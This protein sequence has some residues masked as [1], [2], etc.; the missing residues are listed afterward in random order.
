MNIKTAKCLGPVADL[1]KHLPVDWWRSIFNSIYL[2]T[3]AD[4]VENDTATAHEIDIF[5][6]FSKIEPSDH[7]LDLCCGQGRHSLELAKRGY[8]FITGIDRSR[9][10]IRLARSRSQK[11]GYPIKFSEGDARKVKLADQSMDCVMMMGNS[12]GY[13]EQERDDLK[14]L[15]EANRVL[16]EGGLLYLDVTNGAWMKENYEKRS[17]EWISEE[18]MVCRERHLA[19]DLCRLISR[20]LVTHA[21]K[22]VIADQFYAERLY[23]FEELKSLLLAAGFENIEQQDSLKGES[24]RNQDLGMMA[25]RIL[26]TAIAPKKRKPATRKNPFKIPCTVLLG[27]PRIPDAIKRDGQFN[28]EDFHTINQMKEALK[29]IENFQFSC[30]DDHKNLIRKFSQ[31]PPPFVMNLCDEGWNNDPFMELHPTALMEMLKI[32]YTGAGPECLSICYN[33]ST[34]RAIAQSMDV[35]VPS[36]IWI[37]P[38]NH[39]AAIP[40]IFPALI[41]PAYGDSSIGI[42]QNAVVYSAEELVTYFDNLKAQMPNIP[43]LIQEFLDGREFSVGVIGNG[44]SLEVLPILEVDYSGLPEN[45]PKILGYESKWH[46]ESPYC[47]HI[48]YHQAHLDES[49]ARD[50]I[51]TSINLFQR[52][53]CRDYARFDFRMDSQGEAKLLEANPNPGWCWDGKMALMAEFAGIQYHELLEKILKAAAERYPYLEHAETDSFSNKAAQKLKKS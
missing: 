41:K 42:T 39:S 14:V 12:F 13:F 24:F 31:N 16:C 26:I 33:K 5:L 15:K 51:D 38:S 6:N 29:K 45:L 23:S 52:L 36:E 3:D 21:E 27:D 40:S 37:D 43:I 44:V 8:R 2:K 53:K 4:V 9:Y 7:I 25:N 35:H 20:E 30:F 28:L 10:L 50:L 11:L 49:L 32:P 1:E 19:T 46:P 47:T 22:G 34:V 18:L 48:R 17:W